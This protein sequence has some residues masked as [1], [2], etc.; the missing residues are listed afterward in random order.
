MRFNLI[1]SIVNFSGSRPYYVIAAWV[2]LMIIAAGLSQEYLDSA[3][4]GNGQGATTDLEYILANK[5]QDEKM[6]SNPE[7]QKF[8]D[9]LLLRFFFPKRR[10]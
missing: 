5:L 3:L 4:S 2:I 9:G 7:S 10:N 8:V 1:K 6:S